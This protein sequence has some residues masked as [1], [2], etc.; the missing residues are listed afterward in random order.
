MTYDITDRESFS[1]IENWMG[2]VEKHAS[3]NISRILVGN[4]S[5]LEDDRHIKIEEGKETAEH[6][7]VRFLETSAKDCKNVEEAFTM[8]T[9]E[10]KSI[11]AIS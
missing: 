1:A 8:M 6:Y 11:V 3:D 9:R 4:K 7:N 5:D 10:I 2:E